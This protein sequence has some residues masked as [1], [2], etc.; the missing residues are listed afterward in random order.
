[1]ISYDGL[2]NEKHIN[3]QLY[4]AMSFYLFRM[5]IRKLP[6]LIIKAVPLPEPDI[7]EGFSSRENV[8]MLCKK[9]A[10]RS[11]L[12]VTDQK[13][14]SLGFHEK[15][16]K[17]LEKNGIKFE[18]FANISSEPS[19]QTVSEGGK[20]AVACK[21][22]C[23]L[24]LGG[25]SVLDTC[26]IIAAY[27]A[28]PK[29]KIGYFL[30]KFTFAKTLPMISIPTTAGTG[31]EQ[32]VG[33][34]IKNK[35]GAKKSTVIVGLRVPYVILDSELTVDAPRSVTLACGIDA[36]S[37]G[38]EGCMAD[39]KV[40]EEDEIKSRECVRL[41]LENL[42]ELMKNPKDIEKRQKLCLAAN[43]GGNAINKQLA[44]YIHAF[45]H[46]LGA[47]YHISHGEAI[48]HCLL[49]IAEYH[50]EICEEKL[51]TL[52]LYCGL[53][54]EDD[55]L[56]AAAEKL[57]VKLK[58]LLT[59]CGFAAGFEKLSKSDYPKLIK[60]INADSVNYSPEKTLTDKEIVYL[61]E[62]IRKEI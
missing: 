27:A 32:T 26:K 53:A 39:V 14:L 61:L 36:L 50:K 31:A 56:D 28:H 10:C 52:S 48:A 29:R 47:C 22:D 20:T 23:I 54:S 7:I 3:L 21:A 19:V 5:C 59:I 55:S 49:P 24:A 30:Q 41:V 9:L 45:A 44:G 33:A 17:S 12:L 11:A 51:G 57:L 2:E 25:G 40:S 62:K 8:G 18:I 38:L 16:V 15:I 37:H 1:M 46:T 6:G 35:K 34:I 42:P 60:G 58:E 4:S 13:L 43:Y